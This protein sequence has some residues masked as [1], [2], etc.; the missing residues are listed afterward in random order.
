MRTKDLV[1]NN[2]FL[3]PIILPGGGGGGGYK[4]LRSS[5]VTFQSYLT[6]MCNE[7]IPYDVPEQ[8]CK[9]LEVHSLCT[10]WI[11]KSRATV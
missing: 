9:A 2:L 1:H 7:T 4:K 5:K 3:I 11:L 10:F 8:G 6:G